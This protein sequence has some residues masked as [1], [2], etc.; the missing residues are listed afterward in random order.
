MNTIFNE[1]I[2][3]SHITREELLER[4]RERYKFGILYT[5][6]RERKK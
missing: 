2:L 1:Q 3:F 4:D 5:G 6:L